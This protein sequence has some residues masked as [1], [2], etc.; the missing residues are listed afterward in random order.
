MVSFLSPSFFCIF[1]LHVSPS[2]INGYWHT[3]LIP[4]IKTILTEKN[5]RARSYKFNNEFLFERVTYFACIDLYV[6]VRIYNSIVIYKYWRLTKNFILMNQFGYI[7]FSKH[8]ISI[9]ISVTLRYIN[10]FLYMMKKL[11]IS[12]YLWIFFWDSPRED[13]YMA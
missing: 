10:E 7:M 3:K 6:R 9:W 1:F 2:I 13:T 4:D 12:V 5:P 11:F 8:Y